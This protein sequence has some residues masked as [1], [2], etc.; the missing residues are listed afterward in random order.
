MKFH[1]VL[2]ALLF[3]ASSMRA[4]QGEPRKDLAKLKML[5]SVIAA[6]ATSTG[7]LP[8]YMVLAQNISPAVR[9]VLYSLTGVGAVTWGLCVAEVCHMLEQSAITEKNG[10]MQEPRPNKLLSGPARW[11]IN[12]GHVG[13]IVG[14][15]ALGLAVA[16]KCVS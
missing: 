8:L 3:V 9:P 5:T 4:V 11:H 10:I 7:V 1:Y 2:C 14:I 16:S 15:A 12:K 13:E 6:S